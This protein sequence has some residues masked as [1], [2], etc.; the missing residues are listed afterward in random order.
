MKPG[1]YCWMVPRVFK[2]TRRGA[3]CIRL[4]SSRD[5]SD[6]DGEGVIERHDETFAQLTNDGFLWSIEGKR[7]C[8]VFPWNAVSM[9]GKFMKGPRT[10]WLVIDGFC[11]Q[12][13][14]SQYRSIS[15]GPSTEGGREQWLAIGSYLRHQKCIWRQNHGDQDQRNSGSQLHGWWFDKGSAKLW[16]RLVATLLTEASAKFR[17]IRKIHVRFESSFVTSWTPILRLCSDLAQIKTTST[18]HLLTH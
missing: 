8:P 2:M 5:S 3:G 17:W 12:K 13:G 4:S 6:S 9:E 16:E 7:S 11:R 14:D 18:E 1:K 15:W 10:L